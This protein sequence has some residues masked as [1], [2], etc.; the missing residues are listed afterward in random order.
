MGAPRVTDKVMPYAGCV[1]CVRA[2][3]CR[4]GN[5]GHCSRFVR[6][7]ERWHTRRETAAA[8]IRGNRKIAAM[9]MIVPSGCRGAT[10]TRKLTVAKDVPVPGRVVG[11]RVVEDGAGR[12]IHADLTVLECHER[13][14]RPDGSAC[15]C[16]PPRSARLTRISQLPARSATGQQRMSYLRLMSLTHT[17][18]EIGRTILHSP[19]ERV[20]RAQPFSI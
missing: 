11:L 4:R 18:T 12:A 2:L 19:R 1:R 3:S 8:V 13:S 17:I 7:V 15:F 10:A 14:R 6:G 5:G 16:G 9:M 20:E